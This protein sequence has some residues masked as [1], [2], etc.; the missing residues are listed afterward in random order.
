MLQ[1]IVAGALTL[2]WFGQ[3]SL[4]VTGASL[5]RHWH[6]A[7]YGVFGGGQSLYF[8]SQGI[9]DMRWPL[10]VTLIRFVTVVAGGA[11]IVGQAWPIEALFAIVTH[12]LGI[13]GAGQAVCLRTRAWSSKAGA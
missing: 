1:I 11:F 2:G 5:G 8:A 9:G 10:V 7:A 13:S 4:G 3:P 6:G 12:G